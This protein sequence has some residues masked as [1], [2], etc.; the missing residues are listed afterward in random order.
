MLG[1]PVIRVKTGNMKAAVKSLTRVT[2]EQGQRAASVRDWHALRTTWATLAISN[3]VPLE[4]VRKVTGHS[5]DQ[6]LVDHYYRP[7]AEHARRV[8]GGALPSVI[9]GNPAALVKVNPKQELA[10][11][12]AKL[13]TGTATKQERARFKKLAAKI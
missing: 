10:D 3:G 11:L 8:L 2:R 7:D 9:T 13:A 12:A 6:I 5:T 1:K 4:D